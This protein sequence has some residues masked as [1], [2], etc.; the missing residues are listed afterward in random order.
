MVKLKLHLDAD[1]SSKSLHLALV[2]KGH[3]VT[4]TPN[5]WMPLDA[6]DE[7][8]LLRATSQGRCIFYCSSRKV[9]ATWWYY[10]CCSE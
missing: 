8:Q 2:S 5:D 7:I 1:T 3:D 10:P 4:R 6:S 9:S